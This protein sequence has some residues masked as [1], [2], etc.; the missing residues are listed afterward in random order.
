LTEGI[1]AK[2]SLYPKIDSDFFPPFPS[3]L[4]QYTKP[5]LY[6]AH[7]NRHDGN[8][9][10]GGVS[11]PNIQKASGFRDKPVGRCLDLLRTISLTGLSD[12]HP[13]IVI[14]QKLLAV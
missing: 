4:K 2:L 6:H 14:T 8:G 9:C 5:Q 10:G 13:I 1:L 11:P 3:F 7:Q 12:E